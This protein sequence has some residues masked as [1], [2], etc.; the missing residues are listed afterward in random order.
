MTETKPNIAIP[1]YSELELFKRCVRS[2]PDHLDIYAFDGRWQTFPGDTDVTPGAETWC[3]EQPNV[4]YFAPPE[5]RRP[6]GSDRDDWHPATRYD[7]TAE[8][9]FMHYEILPEDEWVLKLDADETLERYDDVFE[10]LNPNL[11]Y[12]PVVMTTDG[13]PLYPDR[14]YVPEHWTFW[15]DDC[16]FPRDF[17]PRDTPVEDLALAQQETLHK[18]AHQG[19]TV[20]AIAIV[21]HGA[22][23]SEGYQQR[24]ADHL[25]AMHRTAR[26]D[27]YRRMLANGEWH[28]PG[29]G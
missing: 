18:R 25:E 6:W 27:E 5:H 13:E 10:Q 26:A 2:I 3:A 7:Q 19:G 1:F 28:R 8:A 16:F 20:D 11:K 21:N 23:R 12:T 4:K 17:Y 29:W 14:I 15:L 24:R 9:R 22:D